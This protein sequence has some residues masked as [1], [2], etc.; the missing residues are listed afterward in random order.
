MINR[1]LIYVVASIVFLIFFFIYY[2]FTQ[3]L[4]NQ[5][6][7]NTESH[8]FYVGGTA[9]NW[10]YMQTIGLWSEVNP[11]QVLKSK[12]FDWNNVRVRIKH[13]PVGE[14]DSWC[15]IEYAEENLRSSMENGMR[16]KLNFFLSHTDAHSGQQPCPPEWENFTIDEKTEALRQHCY[17]TTKRYKDSG[18]NI[19]L[20]EIG[21]EIDH[22][23]LG[24]Y[25]ESW[26]AAWLKDNIW[27]KEAQML[28][29]AIEG[30]RQADPNATIVLHI[31][32]SSDPDFVYDFFS[33]MD[34]FGVDYD[35]AGLSFYPTLMD[36]P[37]TMA[38]LD[39]SVQKISNLGKKT[40][41]CEFVYPSS[42]NDACPL[43][44]KPVEGYPFTPEGQS[45][46][47]ADFLSWAHSNP[48][49]VGAFYFYPEYYLPETQEED[50]E[51]LPF[52]C[53]FFD[54]ENTK[55][56]MDVFKI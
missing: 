13:S 25:S 55:P 24:E 27:N 30:V 48:N 8:E 32:A 51:E 7:S 35:I 49:V 15:S 56:A 44:N 54:E 50:S 36:Y 19:E 5:N 26:D 31:A 20:Y 38:T 23:I 16:L 39:D 2:P 12:G 21:N 14:P 41:I 53:L 28:K 18:L 3:Q 45:E 43:F 33:S 6:L 29:G 22:G 9:E 34:E 52:S 17:D 40:L 42:S 47:I 4:D 37:P 46:Y 1:R 10:L 11:L